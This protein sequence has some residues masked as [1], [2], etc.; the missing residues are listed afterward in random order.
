MSNQ[1]TGPSGGGDVG[2][3]SGL[4]PKSTTEIQTTDRPAVGIFVSQRVDPN[5]VAGAILRAQRNGFPTIVAHEN[6]L[7]SEAVQF[8]RQLGA[9]VVDLSHRQ[10]SSSNPEKAIRSISKSNGFPGMFWQSDPSER[11]DFATSIEQFEAHD[12]YLVEPTLKPDV[13]TDPEVLVG[14]PAYEEETTIADV[15]SEA[16]RYADEVLVVDD[17]SSDATSAKA[18]DAGATVVSHEQ[19]QGYGAALKTVFKEAH[20]SSVDHL[21]ILDGDGQHDP[22]DIDRLVSEQRDEDAEIVIGSRF[23]EDAETNAP[24]YRRFGLFV[25]NLLTNLS[26]GVIRPKSWTNDTQSGFRAYDKRAVESLAT[27]GNIGD[28]MS[29]STDILHHAHQEGFDV[30]EVGTTVDYDIK[31]TSSQNPISH[32]ITLVSN[33]LQ[34]IERD[35]PITAVGVPGFVSTCLGLGFGYWTFSNY[36]ATGTFP[37]GLAVTSA[38]FGLAGIFMSFTAII[39]HSLNQQLDT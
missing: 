37:L 7:E 19:N 25:V 39:L 9:T 23:V 14:I 29:A 38:F 13:E 22:S 34:T 26:F 24:L 5:E 12:S 21:V 28:Q 16:K 18:R 33:I 32:G 11:I 31:G 4:L 27:N 20:R 6:D 35:R 3:E 1:N 2:T 15:V 8:A 30:A 36:I 10:V 17:G